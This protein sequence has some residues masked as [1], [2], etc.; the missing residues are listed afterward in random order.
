[1]SEPGPDRQEEPHDPDR[2]RPLP[3]PPNSEGPPPAPPNGFGIAALVLAVIGLAF[4]VVPLGGF[5]SFISGAIGTV[6]GI[7]GVIR[8]GK[9]LANLW[10]SGLGTALSLLALVLGIWAMAVTSQPPAIPVRDP[11]STD[12]R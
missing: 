4:E 10:V 6:F 2:Q 9:A 7:L 8:D 1:M 3:T 12:H 5:V 11:G